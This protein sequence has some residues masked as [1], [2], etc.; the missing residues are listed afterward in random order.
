M[1]LKYISDNGNHARINVWLRGSKIYI[2]RVLYIDFDSCFVKWGGRFIE[3]E[4]EI[5]RSDGWYSVDSY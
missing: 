4:G 1:I 5:G 3:V 2:S